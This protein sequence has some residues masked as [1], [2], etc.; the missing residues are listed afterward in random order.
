MEY[1]SLVEIHHRMTSPTC[2]DLGIPRDLG[3]HDFEASAHSDDSRDSDP[4]KGASHPARL[5]RTPT[6]SLHLDLANPNNPFSPYCQIPLPNPYGPYDYA[7]EPAFIRKRNERERERVRCVNEGYAKLREHIPFENKEKRISKVETLRSAIRYI[8]HLQ[9]LLGD[10]DAKLE[11]TRSD[12]EKEN[13]K[14]HPKEGARARKIHYDAIKT[15]RESPSNFDQPPLKK[16][17]TV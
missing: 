6:F 1:E 8:K 4:A 9:N 13:K 7:F 11:E 2:Q 15:E 12:Q 3:S 17:K 10:L 14:E 16:K 5:M